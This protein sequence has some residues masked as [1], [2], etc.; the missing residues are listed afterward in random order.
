MFLSKEVKSSAIKPLIQCQYKRS[1]RNWIPLS[2]DWSKRWCTLPEE[3][4]EDFARRIDE[5][6]TR[7]ADVF[8]VTFMKCGTTWMQELAWLLL[9]QLDFD[10]AKTSH[11]LRRCPHI[12]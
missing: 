8:V 5:F 4:T 3:Y 1:D 12:E 7:D 11:T 2:Q 10:R 9:N 6:E